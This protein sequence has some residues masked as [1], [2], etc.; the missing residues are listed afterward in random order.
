MHLLSV[1][2]QGEQSPD[3]TQN[4]DSQQ[5]GVPEPQNRIYLL[6]HYVQGHDAERVMNL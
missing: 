6:V 5:E 1:Q 4:G 3:K 2:T